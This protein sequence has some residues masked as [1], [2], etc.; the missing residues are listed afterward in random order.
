MVLRD[1]DL[2]PGIGEERGGR[3]PADAGADH[4]DVEILA[5]LRAAEGRRRPFVGLQG[6]DA[7]RQR[8]AHEELR[9]EDGGQG[10]EGDDAGRDEGARFQ[11]VREREEQ[12]E[13]AP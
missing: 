3:E 10:A 6:N 2:Q 5:T 8:D 9:P 11:H 1:D 7:S 13:R 4:G 12:E